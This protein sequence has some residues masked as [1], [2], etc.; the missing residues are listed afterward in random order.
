M[1]TK[2]SSH[3]LTRLH[4]CVIAAVLLLGLGL[5]ATEA[6]AATARAGRRSFLQVGDLYQRL[7]LS[8]D[9][10]NQ[11]SSTQGTDT[12]STSHNFNERY[13]LGFAWLVYDPRILKGQLTLTGNLHQFYHST[14][15]GDSTDSSE[16]TFLY[17]LE[18]VLQERKP[19]PIHFSLYSEENLVRNSYAPSYTISTKGETVS[20]NIRNRY[21]PT[22][23]SYS[24]AE[25]STSGDRRDSN[26]TSDT[27]TLGVGHALKWSDTSFSGMVEKHEVDSD[28]QAS[29]RTMDRLTLDVQNIL[30]R[31]DRLLRKRELSSR[32]RYQ[33][34]KGTDPFIRQGLQEHL[35]LE[36][37]RG[38]VA[39]G[40]Y[41]LAAE[42]SPHNRIDVRSGYFS[43]THTLYQNL[44]TT[45]SGSWS[46]SES[47]S[48][49]TSTRT[50]GLGLSYSKRL[51]EDGN[52]SLAYNYTQS[53]NDQSYKD[54]TVAVDNEE[55][56]VDPT[57]ADGDPYEFS[58]GRNV[59]AD[60]IIVRDASRAWVYRQDLGDYEVRTVGD[61]T[62]VRFPSIPLHVAIPAYDVVQGSTLL[63]SYRRRVNAE[64]STTSMSHSVSG[65]LSRKGGR[66]TMGFDAT[67][68]STE[69]DSGSDTLGQTRDSYTA[70]LRGAINLGDTR[71]YALYR[72][73]D[74]A[75]TV[76]DM[77][78]GT[79]T[80]QRQGLRGYLSFA[81]TDSYTRSNAENGNDS[82]SNMFTA[83]SAYSRTIQRVGVK[84]DGR[85]ENRYDDDGV[86]HRLVVSLDL[87]TRI[88]KAWLAM[89]ITSSWSQTPDTYSRSTTVYLN[90]SRTF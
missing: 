78:S 55:H 27:Y 30:H 14:D 20:L 80:H 71:Y 9:F 11:A 65:S 53:K 79:W 50:A 26:S 59:V 4:Q 72:H 2:P 12:S 64:L 73:V 28:I 5:G 22:S 56:I 67:Y 42:R 66:Y 52:L 38:L 39:N 24:H 15:E 31:E 61:E 44:Y 77:V 82:W 23:F 49:E 63:V 62:Y 84:L 47:L 18:G 43:A 86:R 68:I 81:A 76:T 19:Y 41:T 90:Y 35:T 33:Q 48:G 16:Q 17:R 8:Y 13:T 85:Y 51:A 3:R 7:D 1:A 36:L 40:A 54:A 6:S 37:G 46:D 32:Y 45:L 74:S 21:L 10:S 58:L 34:E 70:G 25:S 83:S 87:K 29:E 60:T 88:R 75:G 89:G 57:L 69:Q